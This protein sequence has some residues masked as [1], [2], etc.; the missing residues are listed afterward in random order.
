MQA[1]LPA[2]SASTGAAPSSECSVDLAL[3]DIEA[4]NAGL[5]WHT[6]GIPELDPDQRW[7]IIATGPVRL[8]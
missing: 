1:G 5:L 8:G 3:G 4:D 6:P 2:C 7:T